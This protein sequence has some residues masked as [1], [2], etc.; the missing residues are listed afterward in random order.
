MN[1]FSQDMEKVLFPLKGFLDF[2]LIKTEEELMLT[3]AIMVKD[4]LIQ[5]LEGSKNKSEEPIQFKRAKENMLKWI[6]TLRSRDT[7]FNEPEYTALSIEI[8]N[9]KLIERVTTTE[10]AEMLKLRKWSPMY[11]E[12]GVGVDR[13]LLISK[14]I[15][16]WIHHINPILHRN[17]K[18]NYMKK[19]NTTIKRTDKEFHFNSLGLYNRL[20]IR[21]EE[22]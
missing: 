18:H 5:N 8:D 9:L 11:K 20:D 16:K 19:L 21:I 7:V 22:R 3:Y 10:T 1:K 2:N 12:I 6:E 4:Y 15:E 17:R 13:T 14:S